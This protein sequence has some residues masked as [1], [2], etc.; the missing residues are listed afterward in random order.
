MGQARGGELFD[1][2]LIQRTIWSFKIRYLDTGVW[3]VRTQH[4]VQNKICA[5]LH[6]NSAP[7]CKLAHLT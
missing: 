3:S 7:S 4:L 2:T 6:T 1:Q 5:R